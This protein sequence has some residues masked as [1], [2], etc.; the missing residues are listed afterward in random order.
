[1]ASH[2]ILEVLEEFSHLPRFPDGRIDYHTSDTAPVV[3]CFVKVGGE[4]LLLKRSNKVLMYKGLWNTVAGYLDEPV[5][6]REKALEELREEVGIREAFIVSMKFADSFR[7]TDPVNG[8]TWIVFA[9]LV[10]LA[11][12]PM[13]ILDFEHTEYR[14]VL[15][16]E[17]GKYHTIPKLEEG[18]KKLLTLSAPQN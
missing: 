10:E 3:N 6:L 1:M 7:F 8:K 12:K 14:W 18:L 9:V 17:I 16:D 15:V 11:E 4:I 2:S 5:T 13:I